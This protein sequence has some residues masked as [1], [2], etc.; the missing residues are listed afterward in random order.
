MLSQRHIADFFVCRKESNVFTSHP[1]GG[2]PT[3]PRHREGEL[4]KI[5]KVGDVA[6]PIYY[7]YYDEADRQNQNI[8]PMEMY[9][10]FNS[11]PVYTNEGIPF[12]TAMQKPCEHFS[13]EPDGDN[14]CYQCSHYKKCEELIGLCSAKERRRS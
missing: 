14:T 2:L 1:G 5:I 13:G 7:G 3:T 12:V 9:P 8:E 11:D 10:D 4:Y 6:F